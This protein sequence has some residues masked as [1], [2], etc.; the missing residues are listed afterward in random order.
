[1]KKFAFLLISLVAAIAMAA[2]DGT[3]KM[4]GS[5]LR[6]LQERDTVL[7][8][9][10]LLYGVSLENVEE[11]TMFALPDYSK[12]IRDSVELVRDWQADTVKIYK[13]RNGAANTYDIDF[14]A[15]ITS[16]E[17]G[18]YELPA[19]SM[20][21]SLPD[22]SIDT[23]LFEPQLL[24]VKTFDVDT[25]SYVPH[26]I[27][28][29]VKYPL[30][31]EELAPYLLWGLIAFVVILGA[32]SLIVMKVR[33]KKL[34]EREK[35]A[36]HIAALRKLDRYRGNKYWAPEK[37]KTFYSG[38]TDTLR[39]Y[40]SEIYGISAMEMTTAEIFTALKETDVPTGLYGETKTLF[41]NSDFVKFA[42]HTLPDE[43][44]AKV[45][46][47][48]IR[49]VTETYQMVVGDETV[50]A[51]GAAAESQKAEASSPASEADSP[52]EGKASPA[53]SPKAAT[54]SPAESPASEAESPAE[55]K[56]N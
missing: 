9:D 24:E 25:T 37:Q 12:G 54:G 41:E 13:G 42:K 43:E 48:A 47:L 17:E 31:F 40:I 8:G 11:G 46:P 52:A 49:F 14:S 44:N 36:P 20:L 26:D 32:V 10:Q 23:L 29:Q 1:M 33:Q 18:S 51:E 6:P 2:P 27:R 38:V 45:L 22:G 56:E 30:T 4:E 15:A 16:F 7:I 5:F 21:R 55:G 39:T 53:E 28:E 34:Q 19:I 3:V 35:E 50:Q